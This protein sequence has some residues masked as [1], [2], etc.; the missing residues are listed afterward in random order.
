[1]DSDITVDADNFTRSLNQFNVTR[2][3]LSTENVSGYI[4]YFATMV[5][6]I[7]KCFM[8]LL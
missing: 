3:F 7:L 5:I 4:T 8:S 1:M 6:D 2:V